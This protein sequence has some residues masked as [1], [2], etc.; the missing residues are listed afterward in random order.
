MIL[1][2]FTGVMATGGIERLSR[3]T[4]AV[5]TTFAQK[6][7]LP[8]TI[9]SLNDP[10][11]HH[12]IQVAEVSF[13]LRGFGRQKS[14]FVLSAL[15]AASRGFLVYI[16]HPNLAPIGLLMKAIRPSLEYWVATYGIDVWEP[17]SPL[18]RLA[19]QAASGV[20][21]ISRYTAKMLVEIQQLSCSKITLIPP[22]LDP[23][24]ASSYGTNAIVAFPLPGSP[25]LLTVARLD[26]SERYKG[27]DTVIQT[28]P[29]VLT[30]LPDTQY[31]IVG[32][33]DDR[34]RL[35]ALAQAVGAA[36][37]VFFAGVQG[38]DELIKYYEVCDVFVM[39]SRAEGF[40]IVFLEAMAFGKPVIGCN[41]GG[42][43][44]VIRDGVFGFLVRYGDIPGL[45]SRILSLLQNES[46]RQQ[47]GQAGR[48]YVE[49][50]FSFA[51][52][53]SRLVRLLTGGMETI[54]RTLICSEDS[55]TGR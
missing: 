50:N 27:I 42:T 47:M 32:N 11:G 4:A 41:C 3:H 14:A 46:L 7:D 16:G 52:L 45:A 48:Q 10:P 20:T 39:P 8:C 36:E 25:I 23:G 22:A 28:L 1:G 40:G 12:A 5:L 43:L 2:L 38:S 9:L 13:T 26:T 6:C 21:T 31:I 15:A 53:Q 35:E 55:E 49:K 30:T 51:Q 37:H 33:G 17:L 34:A 24:F 19:L 44:D 18:R 29:R 54:D